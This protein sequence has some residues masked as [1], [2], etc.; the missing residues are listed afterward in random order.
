MA[1][2]PGR[3]REARIFARREGSGWNRRRGGVTAFSQRFKDGIARLGEGAIGQGSMDVNCPR[4]G[5]PQ[6][7]ESDS[8]QRKMVAEALLEK[9]CSDQG[10]G[11]GASVRTFDRAQPYLANSRQANGGDA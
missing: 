11:S 8:Q 6:D 7:M 3:R 2:H 4:Y 10:A 5:L 9:H 1:R